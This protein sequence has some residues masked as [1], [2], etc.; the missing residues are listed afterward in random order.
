MNFVYESD[1]LFSL[2]GYS[3]SHGLLLLRSGKSN[4]APETR[5]D[6]LFRDVRVMEIRAWMSGIRIEEVS[7]PRFLDGQRSNPAAMLEPGL[8]I[9]SIAS[10]EHGD[11]IG[12]STAKW[13]GFIIAGRVQ[14]E[15][16]KGEMLGPST[17]V[18]DS[19]IK[20][21]AMS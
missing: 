10:A 8:N 17:L 3:M 18:P 2:F 5:V 6:I 19:P 11:A 9:Y 20:R 7:D 1:R 4:G 21:W 12:E 16:D 13:Q 15:E 14:I